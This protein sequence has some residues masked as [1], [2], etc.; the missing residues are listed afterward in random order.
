MSKQALIEKPEQKQSTYD[1]EEKTSSWHDAH[2]YGPAPRHRRR[3]IRKWISNLSFESVLDV[4]C[5]QPFLMQELAEMG[6]FK[7]SGCDVSKNVI[8]DNKFKFPQFNFYSFDIV[9]KKL[10]EKFD[11]VISSEVLEHL[12]SWKKAI[13]N[14]TSMS[15]NYLLITVPASKIYRTDSLVGHLRHFKGSEMADEIEKNGFKIIKQ[16]YWGFP[17]HTIY[18]LASNNLLND[19]SLKS[20]AEEKYDWKKKLISKII[21]LTF[22]CNIN[23]FGFQRF[24]L[25]KKTPT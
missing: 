22:Y 18:K 12:A 20:F 24:I 23:S 13:R 16:A 17:F 21:D 4:G 3:L 19:E 2:L 14:L 7:I 9:S 5:S 25:A 1:Y 6:K 11:L 10:E 8:E 15:N